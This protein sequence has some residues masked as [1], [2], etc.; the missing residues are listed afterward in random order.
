MAKDPREPTSKPATDKPTVRQALT[1]KYVDLPLLE[2]TFSDSVN[3]VSFDGQ[4]LRIEFGVTRYDQTRSQTPTSGR[5]YPACRMV[6]TRS[7]AIEMINRLQQVAAAL[8]QPRVTKT[9][10]PSPAK[11]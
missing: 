6:L 10:A 3:S 5:R 7:A 9:A 1:I 2:E 11:N 4:N 8:N